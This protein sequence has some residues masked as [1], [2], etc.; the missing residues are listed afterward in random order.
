MQ[1]YITNKQK[2][3]CKISVRANV[4]GLCIVNFWND[5]LEHLVTADS[6]NIFGNV[7]DKHCLHLHFCTDSEDLF[8]KR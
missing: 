1:R 8:K 4:L 6:V 5:L 3:D 7:F 2:R